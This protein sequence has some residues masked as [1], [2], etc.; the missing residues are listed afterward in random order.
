[1]NLY[2]IS[3]S[4]AGGDGSDY[5]AADSIDMAIDEMKKMIKVRSAKSTATNWVAEIFRVEKIASD[6]HVVTNL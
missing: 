2:R 1:M 3:V 6:I 4:Y 5:I